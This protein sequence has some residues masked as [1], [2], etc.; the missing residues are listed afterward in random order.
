LDGAFAEVRDCVGHSDR[1]DGRSRL[2]RRPF[3]RSR[4][5]VEIQ[6]VSHVGTSDTTSSVPE[7]ATLGLLALGLAGAGFSRRKRQK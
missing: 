5:S 1:H 6:M 7:P 3:T 2:A 4:G